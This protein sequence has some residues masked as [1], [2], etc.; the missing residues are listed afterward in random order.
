MIR[1]IISQGNKAWALQQSERYAVG[2]CRLP[3]LLRRV[4][5]TAS[6]FCQVDTINK[7]RGSKKRG[8]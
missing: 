8:G 1:L 4:R 7:G 2:S 6:D 5:R 3:R